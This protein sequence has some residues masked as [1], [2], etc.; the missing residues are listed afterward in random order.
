[1]ITLRAARWPQD[2]VTLSLL[3]T[4]FTTDHIYRPVRTELAFRL[5]AVSVSPPLRKQYPFHPTESVER[6]EWDYAAVA[7]V[8]GQPAGFVAAQFVAWNRRVVLHHLY[9]TPCHRGKGMGKLLLAEVDT[10]AR[11]IQ[12]RCL[13]LETQNVN[14]PAIQFYRRA[15][16]TFCGFDTSLYD[17]GSVP[18]EEIALFFSRPVVPLL[19]GEALSMNGANSYV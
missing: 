19:E 13:W 1:M 5:E 3:D 10:F 14:Y 2:A 12:A 15:N 7:E 18:Q 17:P 6:A 11:S 9:I 4:S 8:D 16:F